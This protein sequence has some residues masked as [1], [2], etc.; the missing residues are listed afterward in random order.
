MEPRTGDLALFSGRRLWS[1]LIRLRSGSE[2]SHVGVFVEVEGQLWIVEALE[3]KG[4]R[5]VRPYV[6]QQWRG[7]CAIGRVDGLDGE[8]RQEIKRFLLHRIGEEYASP[9]QFV[10]SFSWVW[11]R[12]SRAWKLKTDLHAERWFC[13]ELAAFALMLVGVPKFGVPAET[14]PGDLARLP[15]VTVAPWIL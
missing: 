8:Q 4:V 9:R 15:N 1:R 11:R 10:R 14:T 3:G 7:H 12:I 6:W 2:W 5:I 13:S